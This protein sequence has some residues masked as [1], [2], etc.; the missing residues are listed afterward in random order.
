LP[1]RQIDSVQQLPVGIAAVLF[2]EGEAP[3]ARLEEEAFAEF[4]EELFNPVDDGG[5]EVDFGIAGPLVQAEEF[6]NYRFLE[7]VARLG[8][9]LAFLGE[10]ADA[11]F[12]AAEGEALVE[13][14]IEFGGGVREPVQFW[15]AASIS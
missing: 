4:G 5:F 12:V 13:A 10:A 9:G 2:V 7:E 14:G 8:D 11:V 15:E 1:Q 6:E 3:L